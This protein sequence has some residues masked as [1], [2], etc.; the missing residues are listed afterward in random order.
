M[1]YISRAHLITLMVLV[2]ILGAMLLLGE[3]YSR[4]GFAPMQNNIPGMPVGAG[5]ES[6]LYNSSQP[7]SQ[8]Q[9]Q[10]DSFVVRPGQSKLTYSEALGLYQGNILQFSES[11]QL[12]T[13]SRSFNFSNEI[14]VDNRSA[15][16]NTFRVGSTSLVVG[17]YDFGFIVLKEKGTAIPVDC[18]D[19]KN[20]ATLI[21][22]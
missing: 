8:L 21:V 6:T 20:V 19:R 13:K 17:P 12:A 16:P 14:M 10:S 15:K 1:K 18:G 3:R 4:M 22:Q 7:Q 11:C 9:M 5:E 2:V